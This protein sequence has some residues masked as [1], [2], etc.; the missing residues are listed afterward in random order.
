MTAKMIEIEG[1][2]HAFDGMGILNKVSFDV[3]PGEIVGVL[4]ASGSGKTTLLRM[5]AGFIVPNS[6]SIRINGQLV[7]EKGR[8]LVPTEARG[9]GLLF[10]DFAL[11]PHMTVA[12]NV[13]YGLHRRPDQ[14]Q[15]VE[16]LMSA[17]GLDGYHDR[18]PN[19]LSGGQKQRVALIR[20]L[21][22]KPS[23]VLLD[24]PFANL[25]A[26]MRL[27][28]GGTV[29]KMLK[30]QGVGALLVTHDRR[31]AF[32]L[33]DRVAILGVP[34]AGHAGAELL[35]LDTPE[36]L[37]AHPATLSVA[38][39]TGTAYALSGQTE[40]GVC[41]TRLGQLATHQNASGFGTAIIRYEQ[42]AFSVDGQGEYEVVSSH[43]EGPHYMLQL[44]GPDGSV[45]VSAKRPSPIGCRGRVE[46]L[47]PIAFVGESP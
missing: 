27:S 16:A 41:T 20:A 44:Q 9:V 10:Q 47:G 38:Q 30:E 8:E 46:V 29:R 31:E 6:G 42:L 13:A 18:M 33:C 32:A 17:V 4:G 11:F 3:E 39:M 19:T 2:S 43:F 1:V 12:D 35:Q 37:Y 24:E 26:M 34:T 14:R 5:L 36:R 21:A 28:L 40:G 25:D 22:P 15:T 23:V 7:A 45:S